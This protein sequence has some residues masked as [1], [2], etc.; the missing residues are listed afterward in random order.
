MQLDDFEASNTKFFLYTKSCIWLSRFSV[1]VKS[2]L[3][4]LGL[5]S[6]SCVGI[7]DE[8]PA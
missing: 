4:L 6:V 1:E 3:G 2:L 7:N 5:L 8:C